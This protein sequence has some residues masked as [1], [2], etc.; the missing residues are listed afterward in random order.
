MGDAERFR[1][2]DK[3]FPERNLFAAF[4]QVAKK[5]DGAPASIMSAFMNSE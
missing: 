3:V 1:L 2:F 4:Q 5:N